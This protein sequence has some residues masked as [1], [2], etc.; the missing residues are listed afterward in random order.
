MEVT[1]ECDVYA[2][3]ATYSNVSVQCSAVL[4]AVSAHHGIL[5][6]NDD[7]ID[8]QGRAHSVCTVYMSDGAKCFRAYGQADETRRSI[9]ETEM[10]H[11]SGLE[12]S[13]SEE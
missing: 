3:C 4:W 10:R 13:V 1:S 12:R 5:A 6:I 2:L 7:D 11:K 8:D 9:G